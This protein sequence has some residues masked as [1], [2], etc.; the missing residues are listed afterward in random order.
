MQICDD[1]TSG[2]VSDDEYLHRRQRSIVVLMR[3]LRHPDD[4]WRFMEQE[5]R[6]LEVIELNLSQLVLLRR[7]VELMLQTEAAT[8]YAGNR[9]LK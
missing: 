8:R 9:V 2:V 3:S 1:L 7:H 4:A 6:I 5:F